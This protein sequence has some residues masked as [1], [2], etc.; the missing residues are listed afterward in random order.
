MEHRGGCD[1]GNAPSSWLRRPGTGPGAV[2]GDAGD[3]GE[4]CSCRPAT[5]PG[6]VPAARLRRKAPWPLTLEEPHPRRMGTA[7]RE[8]GPGRV[9][10]A[11]PGGLRGDPGCRIRPAGPLPSPGAVPPSAPGGTRWH[12]AAPGVPQ[13]RTRWH[14]RHAQP[15]PARPGSARQRPA[16]PPGSAAAAPPPG[17]GWHQAHRRHREHHRPPTEE[18]T[19]REP[20]PCHRRTGCRRPGARGRYPLRRL[21]RK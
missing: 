18:L 15:R 3:A 5:P 20:H 17:P 11:A 12:P 1:H 6:R 14:T 10:H 9:A 8:R 13:V 2:T 16:A 7:P 21:S 4:A 19:L